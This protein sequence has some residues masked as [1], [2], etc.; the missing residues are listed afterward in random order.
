MEPDEGEPMNDRTCIVTRQA[1]DP[2]SLLRFVAAPDGTVTPDL[3]RKL[4]G[5]G[6]WVSARRPVLEEA[7]R[8]KLFGRG[9]KREVTI[10]P[11][12]ADTVDRLLVDAA[13]GALSMARKAGAVVTGFSKVEA[14]ARSKQ[15]AALLHAT[16][17]AADGKRKLEQAVHAAYLGEDSPPSFQLFSSGQMGLALGAENVV[18]AAAT[19]GGASRNLIRLIGQ[20]EAYR[21]D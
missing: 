16:D 18:H 10:P 2:E 17:A 7:I 13:L 4:P 21:R 6:V 8:R 3:R 9:L 12:L 5:R 15:A 20:V 11:D 14:L 1:G 19:Q